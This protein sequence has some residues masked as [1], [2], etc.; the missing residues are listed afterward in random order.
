[1]DMPAGRGTLNKGNN[2]MVAVDTESEEE[3]ERA[4]N[5]LAEGA[6]IMMPIAHQFWG[7][8][9]GMLID[10]FGVQWMFSYVK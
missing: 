2:F 10:K 1:M 4:F 7:A 9:F 8:Y 3:T 6:T 5:G